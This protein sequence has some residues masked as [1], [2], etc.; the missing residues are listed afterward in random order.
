MGM[1][2]AGCLWTTGAGCAMTAL[3]WATGWSSCEVVILCGGVCGLWIVSGCAT[4]ETR[5]VM[6]ML[7]SRWTVVMGMWLVLLLM[8]RIE[9]GRVKS[10]TSVLRMH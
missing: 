5:C 4:G 9:I 8:V 10:G 3:A 7:S 2:T 6:M 1:E